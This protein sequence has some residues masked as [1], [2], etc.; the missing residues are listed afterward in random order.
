MSNR[1]LDQ[2]L[3]SGLLVGFPQKG[4]RIMSWYRVTTYPE[5]DPTKDSFLGLMRDFPALAPYAS[6]VAM[7]T[8]TREFNYTEPYF[9][10]FTPGC[11]MYCPDLLKE[12]GAE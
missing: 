1:N 8:Q 4:E 2:K 5:F 12:Y 10:Y 7:F 3:P 11:Q 6:G 9:F